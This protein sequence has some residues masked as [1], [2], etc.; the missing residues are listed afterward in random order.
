MEYATHALER[1]SPK[2]GP[3][4]GRCTKCGM[5]GLQMSAVLEPCENLRGMSEDDALML[6][7]NGPL[8]N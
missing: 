6:A 7:I 3:F 4:V 2:G 8:E 1:T 5:T